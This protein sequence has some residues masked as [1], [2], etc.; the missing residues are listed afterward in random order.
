MD[1]LRD[2]DRRFL[3]RWQ[4]IADYLKYRK[5]L[6]DVSKLA[7]RAV[8]LLQVKPEKQDCLDA[9]IEELL[10]SKHF[11]IIL[12]SRQHVRYGMYRVF[13]DAMARHLLD[14]DWDDIRS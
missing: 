3:T 10:L 2:T 6:L 13:A 14:N 4:L 12:T 11:E 8:Q 7:Y 1:L 9:L 5:E